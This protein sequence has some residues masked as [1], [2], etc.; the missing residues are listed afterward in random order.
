V[1]NKEI[2]RDWLLVALRA[3]GG[4]ATITDICR[5]IWAHHEADLRD[6]G[7]LFYTWQYDVRWAATGLRKSGAMRAASES[8][9][10]VW[11]LA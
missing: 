10:G 9:R 3:R 11:E 7:D 1:A 4:Q 2:L 5:Q 6:S 8:P